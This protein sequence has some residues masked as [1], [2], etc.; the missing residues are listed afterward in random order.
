VTVIATGYRNNFG[1][2]PGLGPGGNAYTITTLDDAIHAGEGWRVPKTGFPTER[3]AH[4]AARNI[5]AHIRGEAPRSPTAQTA[6]WPT[7]AA[8]AI[9]AR[10]CSLAISARRTK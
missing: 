3:M 2:V 8:A 1:V 6:R 5:A 10:T 4:V 7:P 9:S